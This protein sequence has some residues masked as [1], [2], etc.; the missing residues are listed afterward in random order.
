MGLLVV[1]GPAASHQLL[2]PRVGSGAVGTGVVGRKEKLQGVGVG[3][4]REAWSPRRLC[5]HLLKLSC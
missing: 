1:A 3:R 5:G 4:R 2:L